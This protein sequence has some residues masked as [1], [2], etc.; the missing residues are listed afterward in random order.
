[1]HHSYAQTT[2]NLYDGPVP[3]SKPY[4]TQELWQPEDNGDTIVHYTSV[5]DTYAFP[6]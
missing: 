3:N 6:A 1:M 2:I 5:P 4:S